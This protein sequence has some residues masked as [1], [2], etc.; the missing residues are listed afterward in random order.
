V[1]C[2]EKCKTE[3]VVKK[4]ACVNLCVNQCKANYEFNLKIERE[5]REAE[6]AAKNKT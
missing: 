6:E 2:N 3:I 4:E 5:R 1:T